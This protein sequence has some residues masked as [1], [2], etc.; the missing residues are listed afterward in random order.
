MTEELSLNFT[1]SMKKLMKN[2]FPNT[3]INGQALAAL[4]ICANEVFLY[5]NN[6]V[7][8]ITCPHCRT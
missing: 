6:I 7:Y 3:R 8:A 2:K 1:P 4:G 5:S